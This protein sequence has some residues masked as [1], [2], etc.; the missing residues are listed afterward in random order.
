MKIAGIVAFL[1][2]A[3]IGFEHQHAAVSF[4]VTAACCWWLYCDLSLQPQQ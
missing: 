4:Y 1:F 3:G 2:V